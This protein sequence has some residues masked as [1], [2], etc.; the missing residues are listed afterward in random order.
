MLACVV[1]A[2]PAPKESGFQPPGWERPFDPDRDCKFIQKKDALR[3]ELP[4]K[5]H[6]LDPLRGRLNAPRLLRTV[7]GDFTLVVR[8][9]ADFHAT[10]K[11]TAGAYSS[12]CA[13]VV[14][15]ADDKWQSRIR[16]EAGMSRE[17]GK[18]RD[19]VRQSSRALRHKGGGSV[20][21]DDSFAAWP[22]KRGL[23]EVYLR[24]QRRGRMV[25][26]EVSP[27]GKTWTKL[28]PASLFL[29]A[30]VKV[31]LFACSTSDR[32]L[33]ATFDEFRLTTP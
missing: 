13:G 19:Y 27:D 28:L 9:K 2:A 22:L 6:D 4:A 18:K 20:T 5:D 24:I 16:Y 21:F 11:P 7:E 32:P 33:K 15:E 30:K 17:S 8:I 25:P 12:S 29:P 3:I 26:G 10:E 31:G 14:I 23:P 1:L